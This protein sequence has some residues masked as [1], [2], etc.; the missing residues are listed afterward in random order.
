LSEKLEFLKRK[1]DKTIESSFRLLDI[2]VIS[3]SQQVDELVVKEQ[4]RRLKKFYRREGL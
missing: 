2:K 4:R 3:L 1:L